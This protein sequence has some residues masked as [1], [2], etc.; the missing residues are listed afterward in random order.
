MTFGKYVLELAQF[1]FFSGSSRWKLLFFLARG[2]IFAHEENGKWRPLQAVYCWVGRQVASTERK[3]IDHRGSFASFQFVSRNNSSSDG[4]WLRRAPRCFIA[5]DDL[6]TWT[7]T[8]DSMAPTPAAPP[9]TNMTTPY[10]YR[11]P[12][13]AGRKNRGRKW[14]PMYRTSLF[15]HQKPPGVLA[16]ETDDYVG[17]S[18]GSKSVH[19]NRSVQLSA[20]DSDSWWKYIKV[21]KWSDREKQ[22]KKV[23]N[24]PLTINESTANV[25]VAGIW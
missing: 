1:V 3:A 23:S 9:S 20:T 10:S 18:S 24:L 19:G 16:Q 5:V 12:L 13:A 22:W 14:S 15:Q 8:G 21:C 7:V 4:G 2:E 17:T 11:P 6:R 25:S